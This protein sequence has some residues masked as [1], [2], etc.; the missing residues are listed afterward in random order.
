MKP[1]V[2]AFDLDGTVLHDE[3]PRMGIP[4][5]GIR[6]EMEAL[7]ELKWKIVIWTVRNDDEGVART[8]KQHNLPF[9]YINENPFGPPNGS[10]KI[11]ADAYVDDRA[12]QFNGDAKGL[13]RKIVEFKPWHKR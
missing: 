6:A 8:L 10:R 1:K 11:F 13:A 3:F 4:I 2:V 7:R 9:D 12:I 5:D